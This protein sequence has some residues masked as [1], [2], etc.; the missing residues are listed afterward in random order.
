MARA[1]GSYPVGHG[2]KSN[3]RYHGPL[4]K[5]LR[6]RPFTAVTGVRFPYG[7]P[8]IPAAHPGCGNFFNKTKGNRTGA[9]Q[10]T[11]RGTVFP[12]PDR[13][14]RSRETDSPTG[15]QNSCSPSGM[16]MLIFPHQPQRQKTPSPSGKRCFSLFA[17]QR[18][19]IYFCP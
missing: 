3:S 7:S 6:H 2:F 18:V 14:R 10:K 1:T 12:H 9:C 15:H 19:R 13:A 17:G 5:R 11:V 16:R 8:K 4:V